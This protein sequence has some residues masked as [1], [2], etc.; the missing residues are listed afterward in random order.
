[1]DEERAVAVLEELA[2]KKGFVALDAE[3]ILK[4]WRRGSLRFP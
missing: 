3:I 4:E 1:V 2:A